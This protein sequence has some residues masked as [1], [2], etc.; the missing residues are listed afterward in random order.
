MNIIKYTIEEML[1]ESYK[2]IENFIIMKQYH[3]IGNYIIEK[4]IDSFIFINGINYDLFLL[5]IVI[6]L[7][8]DISGKYDYIFNDNFFGS[9][10]IKSNRFLSFLRR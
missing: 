4:Y 9:H 7:E 8:G 3:R 10:E 5:E 6:C 2:A 1:R